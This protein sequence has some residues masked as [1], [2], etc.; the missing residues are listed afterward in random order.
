MDI[1][2]WE[3]L[4]YVM[5]KDYM[6]EILEQSQ[7]R[8]EGR[9]NGIEDGEGEDGAKLLQGTDVLVMTFEG[10]MF[11]NNSQGESELGSPTYGVVSAPFAGSDVIIKDCIFAWNVYNGVSGVYGDRS[12]ASLVCF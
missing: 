3:R 10:C 9:R 4:G 11:Q 5:R 8:V 2:P 6:D 7:T 1:T 12:T